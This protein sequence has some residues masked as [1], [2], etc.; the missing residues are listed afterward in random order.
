LKLI[1]A[2]IF[3]PILVAVSL[4][5]SN[6]L[7]KL[8]AHL[9]SSFIWGIFVYLVVHL[10]WYEPAPVYQKGQKITEVVFK[11]FSPLV[12]LASFFLP[13]F[14]III[15]VAYYL[16]VMALK[17]NLNPG[18]HSYFMFA[19]SFFMVMHIVFTAASLKSRQT[20]FLKANYFF[21]MEFI[22]IINIGIIAGML[23]LIFKEFSFLSFFNG[24]CQITRDAFTAVCNQLFGVK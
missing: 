16:L 24:T 3:F 22:Y 6:E 12:K 17:E 9:V 4:S 15:L 7:Q 11:F 21:A 13:I 10:L 8:N 14:T 18:Y 20:D 1:F 5:F 19:V 23:S 2:I